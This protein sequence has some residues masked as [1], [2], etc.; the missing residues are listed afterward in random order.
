[1]FVLRR[2]G[3]IALLVVILVVLALSVARPTSG[4]GAET[5]YVVKPGDTLWALADER[6]GGDPREGVWRISERN[7]LSSPLLQPGQVLYLPP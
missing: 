4:A 7:A 2:F 6:Y 5:R 1:M 3:I